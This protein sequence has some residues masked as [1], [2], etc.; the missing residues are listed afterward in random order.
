LRETITRARGQTSTTP[1]SAIFQDPPPAPSP[2]DLINF[3]TSLHMLLVLSDVNPAI[4]AQLWS[5]VMYW[6]SCTSFLMNSSSLI[7]I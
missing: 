2:L 6:T 5:Q 7:L 3:L 1:L 4:I